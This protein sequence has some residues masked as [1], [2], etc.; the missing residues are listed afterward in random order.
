PQVALLAAL[1]RAPGNYSPFEHPDVARRR[2]A[3]VL[4]RM[5]EQGYVKPEEAKRASAA[6]LGLVAPERRR[7]SGQYFLE[8]LQQGLEA[9][10][11]SDLVYKGGLSVYTTLNPV[12]QRTAEQALR[13]GLQTLAAR[14]GAK[15]AGKGAVPPPVP[16]G[17]VIVMEPPTGYIK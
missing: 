2:R 14:Q 15:L 1:P 8:Y 16:E 13:E 4:T 3:L 6:P 11:G 12:M 7:G 10:F 9:K 17:A 5:V